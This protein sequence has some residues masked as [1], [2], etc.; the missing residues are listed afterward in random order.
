MSVIIHASACVMPWQVLSAQVLDTSILSSGTLVVALRRKSHNTY[1]FTLSITHHPSTN[2]GLFN[3]AAAV[4][5]PYSTKT[6]KNNNNAKGAKVR[7]KSTSATTSATGVSVTTAT[8]KSTPKQQQWV[9]K[10]TRSA[11]PSATSRNP[12]PTR[13]AG[14]TTLTPSVEALKTQSIVSERISKIEQRL[15]PLE[16]RLKALYELP[17]LKTRIHNAESTITELQAQIQ[18]VSSRT[19][20][21][22]QDNGSTLPNTA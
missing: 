21:M 4:N 13:S 6:P 1:S 18:D 16:K 14:V 3:H 5:S 20:T 9:N 8:G 22:Q 10:K 17:A 7:I 15:G 11:P 2:I 19:P 12:S